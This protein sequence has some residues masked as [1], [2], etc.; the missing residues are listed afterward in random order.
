MIKLEKVIN[1]LK[2]YRYKFVDKIL[3]DKIFYAIKDVFPKLNSEDLDVLYILTKH[4]IEY[5]TVKYFYLYKNG[6]KKTMYNQWTQNDNR[7]I[8]ALMLTLLPF[9]ND[10][11]NNRKNHNLITD[12]N[13][14]LFNKNVTSVNNELLEKIDVEVL[15]NELSVSNFALG[16]MNKNEETILDMY[17]YDEKTI[18]TIIHHNFVSMMETIMITNG[19]LYINWINVVPIIDYKLSDFY[20]YSMEELNKFKEIIST[21]DEK[22]IINII[23]DNRYLWFGDYYNVYRNGYYESIKKIKWVIYN[24]RIN[25]KYWYNIQY[26]ALLFDFKAFFKYESY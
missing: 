13:Q 24:R 18:Y 9:I 11:E 8:I 25:K 19:K 15:N 3:G 21:R 14:I 4:L 10:K 5:T 20:N 12:L 2:N 22:K 23:S 26:L 7:D 6:I 17:M 1:E 16:L